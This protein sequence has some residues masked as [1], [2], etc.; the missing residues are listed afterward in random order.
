MAGLSLQQVRGMITRDYRDHTP[1]ENVLLF[2]Q[3]QGLMFNNFPTKNISLVRDAH[4]RHVFQM[5]H[6]GSKIPP[7]HRLETH[8]FGGVN[9]LHSGMFIRGIVSEL[10]DYIEAVPRQEDLL[11]VAI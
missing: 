2:L 3:G 7:V 4:S 8:K 1:S 6:S 9:W 10:P 5:V 11:D